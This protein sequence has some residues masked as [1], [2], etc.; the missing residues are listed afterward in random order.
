MSPLEP[1]SSSSRGKRD[2]QSELFEK[3]E[4]VLE[5]TRLHSKVEVKEAGTSSVSSPAKLETAT[6]RPRGKS[7]RDDRYD[8][9][10]FMREYKENVSESPRLYSKVEVNEAETSSLSSPAELETVTQR[11]RG[12]SSRSKRYDQSAFMREYKGHVLESPRLH[13]KVEVKEPET[14]SLCS[15][16]ELETVTQR[17]RGKSGGN[18]PEEAEPWASN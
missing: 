2:D 18:V 9:S 13:P 17:P 10:T 8:Q 7:S 3:R 14:S 12:K 11:P 1:S 5:S 15:P 4:H 16:A 6:Q